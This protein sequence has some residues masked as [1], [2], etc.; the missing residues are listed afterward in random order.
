MR[1]LVIGGGLMGTTTAWYLLEAGHEVTLVDRAE[2]LAA[3]GSHANG[4]ILHAGHA[5]PWNSP[6]VAGQLLR[7]VGRERSPL[8]LRPGRIPRMTRWGLGFLRHCRGRDH[9]RVK[10]LNT[11]LAL[12]GRERMAALRAAT[13][14]DYD[15]ARCGS[16]KIFRDRAAL[17]AARSAAA[18]IEGLG[19]RSRALDAEGVL[20]L[21]PALADTR[22]TLAG[23]IHF[24]D[25]ESGDACRFV[26]GLG[27]VLLR[28]GAEV[29]TGESIKRIKGDRSGIRSVVTDRDVIRAD[30]YVVA[31]GVDAAELVRPLGLRLP[32]EPAK[33]YSVT[34]PVDDGMDVPRMPLIDEAHRVVITRLG[35]RLRIAGTVEFAGFDRTIRSARVEIVRRQGLANLPALARRLDPREAEP[36]ACL[37]PVS[38]DGAPILG[39]SPIPGLY[40]NT[41]PGHLGWTLAAAAGSIVADQV[42]DRSPGFEDTRSLAPAR[43]RSMRAASSGGRVRSG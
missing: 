22:A 9:E 37:R 39:P 20:E 17:D 7:W 28:R 42:S 6:A 10:A 21:E 16:M 41:A 31:A 5:A 11:R 40:L 8:L 2:E 12:Y 3:E 30:R 34:L 32:I 38:V 14:I 27:R 15:G 43:F 35:G 36:W 19:I 18:S 4:G 25:D 29:R 33:G 26:R 1:V 13:G 23:G 24:P